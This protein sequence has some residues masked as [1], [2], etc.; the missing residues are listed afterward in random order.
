MKVKILRQEIN[1]VSKDIVALLLERRRLAG[2]VL[3]EK[4]N[5]G[6]PDWDPVREQELLNFL[7]QSLPSSEKNYIEEIFKAIFVSTCDRKQGE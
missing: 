4:R 5:F 2:Q 6:L 1:Q 7:T 3:T